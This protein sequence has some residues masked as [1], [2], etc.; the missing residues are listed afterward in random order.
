MINAAE[1]VVWVNDETGP[2]GTIIE[3]RD[4][5]GRTRA[6]VEVWCE[7]SDGVKTIVGTASALEPE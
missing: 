1:A 6:D 4:E 2:R 7:K 3:T 5:G